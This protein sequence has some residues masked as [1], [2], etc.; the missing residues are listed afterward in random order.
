MNFIQ[1]AK[2]T[3]IEHFS[4]KAGFLAVVSKELPIGSV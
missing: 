4:F 2:E 3:R 1:L